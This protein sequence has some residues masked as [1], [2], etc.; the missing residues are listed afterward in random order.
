MLYANLIE[1]YFSHFADLFFSSK[2]CSVKEKND[3][4][5]RIPFENTW[6]LTLFLIYTISPAPA[7]VACVVDS[8]KITR[9]TPPKIMTRKPAP[10]S[11]CS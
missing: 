11:L 2:S 3:K 9:V 4:Q 8:G 6:C 1:P 10:G 7:N 5:K